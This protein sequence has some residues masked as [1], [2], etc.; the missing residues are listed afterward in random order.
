VP[1]AGAVPEAGSAVAD[2][3]AGAGAAAVA[4]A[5]ADGCVGDGEPEA[6][7]EPL[8]HPAIRTAAIT[9]PIANGDRLLTLAL[10]LD[11]A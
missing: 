8:P 11:S 2:V 6:W 7:P 5:A 10:S 9:E 1:D 4:V 3:A